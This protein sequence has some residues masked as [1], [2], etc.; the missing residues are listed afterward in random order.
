MLAADVNAPPKGLKV[1]HLGVDA[2]YAS[3][4]VSWMPPC[5][6]EAMVSTDVVYDE[7]FILDCIVLIY[8]CFIGNKS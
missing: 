7:L 8:V 6:P 1:S 3:V 5:G 4:E 2:E